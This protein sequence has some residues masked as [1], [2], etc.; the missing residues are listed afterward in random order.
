MKPT[1]PSFQITLQEFLDLHL[2]ELH[3]RP[4]P[5]NLAEVIEAITKGKSLVHIQWLDENGDALSQPV[6]WYYK[7]W[8]D[9]VERF[10]RQKAYSHQQRVKRFLFEANVRIVAR[11]CK[12]YFKMDENWS[13]MTAYSL[14][15]GNKLKQIQV[16]GVPRLLEREDEL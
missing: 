13:Q 15:K 8:A 5:V 14:V 3:S 4:L 10:N 6:I 1:N 16:I 12:E 2:G 9:S 11:A 7:Y